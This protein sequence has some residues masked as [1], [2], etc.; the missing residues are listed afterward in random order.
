[1]L[2]CKRHLQLPGDPGPQTATLIAIYACECGTRFAIDVP[3][4]VEQPAAIHCR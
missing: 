4:S 1:M 2:S 3:L